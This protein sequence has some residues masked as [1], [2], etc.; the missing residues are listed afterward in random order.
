MGIMKGA[1][2]VSTSACLWLLIAAP[3]AGGC[4][5]TPDL[6]MNAGALA[7]QHG[8]PVET[9]AGEVRTAAALTR[10]P[11]TAESAVR[12]ALLNN[13]RL[14]AT[15]AGLGF[16]AADVY[17]SKRLRNPI[18][19]AVALDAEGGAH[20][21]LS[22]SLV[23][24]ITDL[25]TRPAR[26]RIASE[27]FAAA[28]QAVVA[29][30][31]ET[32]AAAE[33]AYYRTVAAR[34]VAALHERIAK[35][36]SLS[37]EL[38]ERF[39]A[40]GNLTPRA[41]ALEQAAASEARLDALTAEAAA[42]HARAELAAALGL[43]AGDDWHVPAQLPA[44]LAQEDQLAKLLTMARQSRPDMVAAN[45]EVA[46]ASRRIRLASRQRWIADI[47]AGIE[48]EREADGVRLAGVALDWALPLSPHRD[49]LVRRQAELAIAVAEAARLALAVENDVR[50]ALATARNA[51]ARARE[52]RDVLIPARVAATAQ[53]Q[54]EQNYML[55]G[56]F[57]VLLEKQR[58]YE[59]HRGYLETVRDYWLAR[60]ALKRAV[61]N[62][63][64]SGDESG[65][66]RI[67]VQFINPSAH[68]SHGGSK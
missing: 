1:S 42:D 39:R 57:E 41:S 13:P 29:A 56:V 60:A 47:D 3:I 26:K 20:G 63:L 8:L 68:A 23:A 24:S 61:G 46:I 64:P 10:E 2:R 37:A 17:Q 49:T 51:A 14:Q 11:L 15:I 65:A 12:L 38:A 5:A 28:K 40:A 67:E 62:A 55:I 35:A 9:S 43:S 34:Q 53:A 22:W 25:L 19:S 31:L 58:E 6:D 36:A 4:A 66:E 50:V 32:A 33:I 27:R 44:P 16:A 54:Q 52:Y 18:L 21:Q 7:V 30:M 45:A 59:A 48:R